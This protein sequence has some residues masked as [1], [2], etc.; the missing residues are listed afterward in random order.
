MRLPHADASARSAPDN[1][2]MAAQAGITRLLTRLRAAP[3]TLRRSGSASTACKKGNRSAR[4]ALL[5]PPATP[6]GPNAER[7]RDAGRALYAVHL[8]CNGGVVHG[9][10]KHNGFGARA[11]WVLTIPRRLA[12]WV[13]AHP[14]PAALSE[15]EFIEREYWFVIP[16]RAPAA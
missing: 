14:V 7:L 13:A 6:L 15:E 2:A 5:R 4:C 3:R 10:G 9:A 1:N 8:S 12:Q 11:T 16:L